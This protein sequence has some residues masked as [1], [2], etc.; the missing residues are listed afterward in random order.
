M[1]SRPTD[2]IQQRL[3]NLN[4]NDSD[5]Q[6]IH[7]AILKI[8]E[9]IRDL[10]K[11]ALQQSDIEAE[12]LAKKSDDVSSTFIKRANEIT[13]G[14]FVV[15]LEPEL[16][17]P[18]IEQHLSGYKPFQE[19]IA[20]CEQKQDELLQTVST[21]CHQLA[22]TAE[23]M[24]IL[25]KREKAIYNLESA[26]AKFKEIRTNLVEVLLAVYGYTHPI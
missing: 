16:F 18:E 11:Q 22:S 23:D 6:D 5:Y 7:K 1:L 4:E 2:E 17:E 12:V 8:R 24:P 13:R 3:P 10:D 20:I 15:K 9:I 19:A 21:L 26:F 14:S 25:K